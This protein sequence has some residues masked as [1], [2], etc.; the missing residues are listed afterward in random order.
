MKNDD[1]VNETAEVTDELTVEAD[2]K[3]ALT[4]LIAVMREQ[5]A[6]MDR[7][8]E[9]ILAMQ[10]EIGLLGKVATGHQKIIEA[11]HPSEPTPTPPPPI[12]H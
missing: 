6:R 12:V 3:E 4:A 1:V 2:A 11:D 5:D 10:R 8:D 7:Q 9:I